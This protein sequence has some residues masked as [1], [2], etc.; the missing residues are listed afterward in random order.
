MN[1]PRAARELASRALVDLAALTELVGNYRVA[2]EIFGFL[3]QQAAEK[4]L[5]AWL[6]LLGKQYPITHNLGQLLKE[7]GASGVDIS[8]YRGL[9]SLNPFAVQFRYESMDSSEPE[10]DRREILRTVSVLVKKVNS[11]ITSEPESGTLLKESPAGYKVKITK[12][13]PKPRKKK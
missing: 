3:A 12:T 5:K 10:L 13:K 4:S 8:G 6:A 11:V 9:G 7:L 2:D 1:D